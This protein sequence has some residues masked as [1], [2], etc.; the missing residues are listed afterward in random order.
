VSYSGSVFKLSYLACFFSK[1]L[2]F[3]LLHAFLLNSLFCIVDKCGSGL[4]SGWSSISPLF[5]LLSNHCF[6]SC[7]MCF[8]VNSGFSLC[9]PVDLKTLQTWS[10]FGTLTPLNSLPAGT[11]YSWGFVF[12]IPTVKFISQKAFGSCLLQ[13][14]A[15]YLARMRTLFDMEV[16]SGDH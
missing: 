12:L 1:S 16:L 11:W 6:S 9:I 2:L 13:F 8:L 10:V 14:L 5:G 15:T 7:F 3:C 4:H